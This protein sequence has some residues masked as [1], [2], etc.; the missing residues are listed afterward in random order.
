M[1]LAAWITVLSAVLFGGPA[2]G[3]IVYYL[4]NRNS[5]RVQ[6]QNLESLTRKIDTERETFEAA[7]AEKWQKILDEQSTKAFE[8]VEKRYRRCEGE[9]DRLAGA[10][11]SAWASF[12][13]FVRAR[14][15]AAR[16]RRRTGRRRRVDTARRRPRVVASHLTV[17]PCA[18]LNR[19][20]NCGRRGATS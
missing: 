10:F 13:P 5:E 16:H 14:L 20:P 2:G 1:T 19:L 9:L 11:G 12:V 3:G 7:A 18:E 17:V 4:Q 6:R 15:A 8:Q